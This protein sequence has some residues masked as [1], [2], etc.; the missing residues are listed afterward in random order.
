MLY[1]YWHTFAGA[2]TE[3]CGLSPGVINFLLLLSVYHIFSQPLFFFTGVPLGPNLV[4]C[5][6]TC[7]PQ[8]KHQTTF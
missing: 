1:K 7:M 8:G 6:D 3:F 5:R 4:S 2:K